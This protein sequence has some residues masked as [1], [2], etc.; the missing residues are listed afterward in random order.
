MGKWLYFYPPL[1]HI[2]AIWGRINVIS[3][4]TTAT[5]DCY[6]IFLKF[7]RLTH[8]INEWSDTKKKQLRSAYVSVYI[9]AYVVSHLCVLLYSC[10]HKRGRT[11]CYHRPPVESADCVSCAFIIPL[12]TISTL[13]DGST[14]T[15]FRTVPL[16]TYTSA[17]IFDWHIH[18]G[19]VILNTVYLFI[20]V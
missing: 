9:L 13:Y 15:D 7:I 1:E 4:H 12:S 18:I 11:T 6:P 17:H 3:T 14:K 16:K 20:K 8:S 10:R 5:I 19:P 2:R